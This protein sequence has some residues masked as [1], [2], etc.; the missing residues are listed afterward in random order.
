MTCK[1]GGD[2]H[3][4]SNGSSGAGASFKMLG[5]MDLPTADA[6]AQV[7]LLQDSSDTVCSLA[8]TD[9]RNDEVAGQECGGRGGMHGLVNGARAGSREVFILAAANTVGDAI[10]IHQVDHLVI[11]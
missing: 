11:H 3:Q 6:S 10:K 8:G 5:R 7:R 1:L 4:G 2:L 9:G